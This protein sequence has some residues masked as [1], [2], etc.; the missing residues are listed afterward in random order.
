M[1]LNVLQIK[2]IDE[3]DK[4]LTHMMMKVTTYEAET[5]FEERRN[6]VTIGGVIK[7]FN[8]KLK[9]YYSK[10]NIDSELFFMGRLYSTRRVLDIIK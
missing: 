7:Y 6:G 8:Q 2:R 3:G 1:V 4:E 9:E 5:I 10:Q